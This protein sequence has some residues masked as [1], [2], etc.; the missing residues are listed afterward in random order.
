MEAFLVADGRASYPM[1]ADIQLHIRGVLDRDLFEA[2][3]EAALV[4]NP[5]FRCLLGRDPRL[6][7]VWLP[8]TE[9]P[10]IGWAALGAP[11][12]ERYDATVDLTTEIGLR[13]WVRQG[14]DRATV[15]L[16]FHHACADALGTFAFVEDL[17]A[18]YAVRCPGEQVVV[19]RPLAPARLL[20][21]G[22]ASIPPR[23]WYQQIFDLLV[24][25][26]EALR[27]FL[28]SPRQIAGALPVDSGP[29]A[30]NIAQAAPNEMQTR[31]LGPALTRQLRGVA[32]E[33]GVTV[34]DLLLCDM[35]AT[36]R[37]WNIEHGQADGRGRLR[38]LMPQN[39]R[40]PKDA[41]TPA[42]NIMSFAFLTRRSDRCQD[43][44]ALHKSVHTETEAI[45]RGRL[46]AYFLGSLATALS[47]GVLDKLLASRICFS[48]VV[49]SNFGVPARRFVTE[50]PRASDGLI[51]GNTVFCGLTGVPPTRPG[52]RAAFA[53]VTSAEDLTISVKCDPRYFAPVDAAR[54]LDEYVNQVA[55]T[56]TRGV[57]EPKHR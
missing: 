5:L 54:L 47:A 13:I 23:N 6:G 25:G 57:A 40:E 28:Q 41:A 32:S 1:M 11:L 18:A 8:T 20:R 26:R 35:F 42:A 39:L 43:S 51:V 52:T 36:M 15:L 56:A 16:H 7:P 21:R 10:S 46:S 22:L 50:F 12:D 53:V 17:L 3:L 49:L 30:Q 55:A 44:R 2:A 38:I 19:Q 45:R 33:A 9:M 27:F 34:N 14:A 31:A 4:R 24:G 29:A 48:T 37:R